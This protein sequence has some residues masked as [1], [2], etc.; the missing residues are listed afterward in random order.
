VSPGEALERGLGYDWADTCAVINDAR[1][2]SPGLVEA[3]RLV[4]GSARSHVVVSAE[5][6]E[7]YGLTP[8]PGARVWRV[9]NV[10]QGTALALSLPSNLVS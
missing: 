1:I 9:A 10:L 7:R 2:D 4:V 5:D 3:L 8:H 6:Q